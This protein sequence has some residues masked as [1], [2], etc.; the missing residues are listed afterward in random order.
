MFL[1][2]VTNLFAFIHQ[3]NKF[4]IFRDFFSSLKPAQAKGFREWQGDR[5]DLVKKAEC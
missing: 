3:Q 2:T 1:V 5:K 4:C